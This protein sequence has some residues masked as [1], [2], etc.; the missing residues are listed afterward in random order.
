M[1]SLNPDVRWI[2]VGPRFTPFQAIL[3]QTLFGLLGKQVWILHASEPYFTA[4]AEANT[5]VD[6]GWMMCYNEACKSG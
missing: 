3:V 1:V 5:E 4:G 2:T 6:G